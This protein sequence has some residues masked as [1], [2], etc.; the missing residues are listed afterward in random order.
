MLRF[1]KLIERPIVI[2]NGKA[3]IGMKIYGEGKLVDKRDECMKYAQT[4]GVFDSMTIGAVSPEQV[5]ENLRLMA[6]YPAS[7]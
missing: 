1:P 6:K 3:I 2:S 7:V 4:C 5:D